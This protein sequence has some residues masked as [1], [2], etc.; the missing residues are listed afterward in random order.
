MKSRLWEGIRIL[1]LDIS[2]SEIQ[3]LLSYSSLIEKWNKVYN[4]TSIR[5]MDKIISHHLLDSLAVLPHID[6]TRCADVGSGA[7]LP[8]IPLAIA[9]PG[10]SVMLIESNKKK[11]AFLRQA[12]IELGLSNVD[13]FPDR[14]ENLVDPGFD[15]VI[16]RAFS[17]I[18]EFIRLSGH[19]CEKGGCLATLKGKYPEE[20]LSRL[21]AGIR[22]VKVVPLKVPGLQGARHLVIMKS[23]SE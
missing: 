14:V 20:E 10:W 17:E 2:E 16:S 21:P 19:L 9:R 22:A 1:G 8:G 3:R 7:G 4:L 15:L 5:G 18:G 23:E 12:C 11:A 6:A 13:V